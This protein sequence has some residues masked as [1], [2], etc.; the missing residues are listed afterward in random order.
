[1]STNRD[2][3]YQGPDEIISGIAPMCPVLV[4]DKHVTEGG[5]A[6]VAILFWG[7]NDKT[8][9]LGCPQLVTFSK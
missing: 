6:N 3:L 2:V 1:M 9:C 8:F 7:G 4:K 5:V